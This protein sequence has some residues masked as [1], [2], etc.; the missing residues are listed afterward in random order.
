MSKGYY[1]DNYHTPQATQPAK[2]ESKPIPPDGK[3]GKKLRA[4]YDNKYFLPITAILIILIVVYLRVGLLQYQ[5]L[6]EPD[7]F[8]YYSLIREMVMNHMLFA[9]HT[10]D[11]SGFP[12]HNAI[13]ESPGLL[14]VTV[15][16]YYLLSFTGLSFYT[17]MRWMPI[18]FGVLEAIT[19]YFLV[20]H[21]SNSKA[22]GLI[23]MA[24][25]ALS[26][27]N[28]ARTAGTVYRGDSFV[29]LF[30][31]LGLLF[32]LKAYSSKD[33]KWVYINTVIA[34]IV[35]S[36]GIIVWNGGTLA[37]AVYLFALVLMLLFAF[38]TADERLAF[39]NTILSASLLLTFGLESVYVYLN[40]AN[41]GLALSP[42]PN[43]YLYIALFF[44]PLILIN[45]LSWILIKKSF[46]KT[47][48]IRAIASIGTIIIFLILLLVLAKGT[49]AAITNQV[50]VVIPISPINSTA[51]GI[52]IPQTTQELQPPSYSFLYSSFGVQLGLGLIAGY[53]LTLANAPNTLTVILTLLL[54][55][56]GILLYILFEHKATGKNPN[57]KVKNIGL[58][59][60]PALI[61]LSAYAF[62][63]FFLQ[64]NAIR[65]NAIISI[66]L[67]IFAAYLIYLPLSILARQE[68]NKPKEII[69]TA[70]GTAI[71][72]A[73]ALF[74]G[75]PTLSTGFKA[76]QA[77]ILIAYCIILCLIAYLLASL[78]LKKIR[79]KYIALALLLLI[80]LYSFTITYQQSSTAAQADGVNPAFLQ[81][82]TWLAGNTPKNAT[83]LALWPDGSVV[84]GWGN[85]TSYID[86]VGGENGTRIY[87]FS[88]YLFNTSLDTQYLYSIGKPQYL[89]ARNFW[90]EELG[91]IAEE[92]SVANV[93]SYGFIQLN[94][95]NSTSNST[96]SIFTFTDTSPPYYRS[97]LVITPAT[98][99]STSF[100]AYLG[101]AGSTQLAEIKSIMLMNSTTS[102]YQLINQTAN[103]I[104]YTLMVSYIGHQI[105]GAYVLGP[106][107]VK[108]N[109]FKF[110]FLC[111]LASCPYSNSN[112]SMKTVFMNGDTRILE[113]NYTR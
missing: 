63:A 37:V 105:T 55:F 89:V 54:A 17:I 82:M 31:M 52:N 109:L 102:Q 40:M 10:L 110:T 44:V 34:S 24:L 86:S 104:N 56:I 49:L 45:L 68:T 7:G 61:A 21:L 50:G 32:M 96:S 106:D 5:G 25:I 47:A 101:Q 4:V 83:V 33:R 66:P 28:I 95:V 38:I 15:I 35:I 78:V 108:S 72:C 19:G 46:F 1:N 29:S 57:L 59:I 91:G 90:Y 22:L 39:I 100:K 79:L 74:L 113:I 26:S 60:S 53:L 76:V 65:Y 42:G 3:V 70:L 69:A 8:F 99:G 16:P 11:I 85:R 41:P 111:N 73:I 51:I 36:F 18:I 62:I 107:L 58:S 93:S 88:N 12:W 80:L 71:I 94:S 103:A 30:V 92:G 43:G 2:P 98:N 77:A 64:T 67:A 14:A 27:G 48:K 75:F 112:A 81:A 20:K 97:A 13:G 87:Y 23:T 84:E 6:F 9:P